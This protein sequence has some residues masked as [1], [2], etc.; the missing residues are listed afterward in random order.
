MNFKNI[1]NKKKLAK[2]TKIFS[3]LRITAKINNTMKTAF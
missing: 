1:F 3:K 2:L